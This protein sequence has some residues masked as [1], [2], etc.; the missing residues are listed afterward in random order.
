MCLNM[1]VNAV[2]RLKLQE[3]SIGCIPLS[4]HIPYFKSQC[5]HAQFAVTIVHRLFW[6]GHGRGM[7][8][9]N[10]FRIKLEGDVLVMIIHTKFYKTHFITL[11]DGQTKPKKHNLPLAEVIILSILLLKYLTTPPITSSTTNFSSPYLLVLVHWLLQW[12]A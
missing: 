6:S 12:L 4:C 1:A 10:A 7:H 3:H 8:L 9:L 2:D 5:P 11:K